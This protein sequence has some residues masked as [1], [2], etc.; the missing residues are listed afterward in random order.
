M[1]SN[2][3]VYCSIDLLTRKQ[4]NIK[5]TFTIQSEMQKKKVKKNH[6]EG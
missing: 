6:H 5:H 1:K 3:E 4:I 2:S